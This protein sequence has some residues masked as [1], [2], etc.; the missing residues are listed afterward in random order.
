MECYDTPFTSAPRIFIVDDEAPVLRSARLMLK[1]FGLS[2]AQGFLNWP[3]AREQMCRRAADLVLLDL[4]MPGVTG[5][6]ALLDCRAHWP[7][8]AVIMATASNEATDAVRCLK[9]GAADYLVKPL[10]EESLQRSLRDAL[11]CH[12]IETEAE[13][14]KPQ[15]RAATRETRAS[16]ELPDHDILRAQDRIKAW[17]RRLS[18]YHPRELTTTIPAD[19]DPLLA[20]LVT[21]LSQP[22][23]YADR[24]LTL[25]RVA[26]D[27]GT[28]TTYL[29]RTVNGRVGRSFRSLLNRVRLA[30]LLD[31]ISTGKLAEFSVEG[32]ARSHGFARKSTFYQ[33]FK[34]EVGA[35]PSQV[36]HMQQPE[37]RHNRG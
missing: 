33:V 27:L 8:T 1:K 5:Y 23:N 13:Q 29:S 37:E 6:Q 32:L 28:N 21:Y 10:S 34:A 24:S 9:A 11:F 20:A 4:R 17:H 7:E 25:G 31:D 16:I 14:Q 36:A 15:Q 2:D 35:T 18:D 22:Q 30:A 19:D 3:D 26:I 12:T